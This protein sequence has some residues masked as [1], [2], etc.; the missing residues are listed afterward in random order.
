V[1]GDV[2]EFIPGSLDIIDLTW[3]DVK[4][5]HY[6]ITKIDMEGSDS[7]NGEPCLW[8]SPPAGYEYISSQEVP[9]DNWSFYIEIVERV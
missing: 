4:N 5:V 3:D 7:N 1:V 8:L 2:V 6:T 9:L